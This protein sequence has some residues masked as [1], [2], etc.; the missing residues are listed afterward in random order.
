MQCALL[1]GFSC[2]GCASAP[3]TELWWCVYC[4]CGISSLPMPVWILLDSFHP[5]TQTMHIRLMGGWIVPRCARE[6]ECWRRR[7]SLR[8]RCQKLAFSGGSHLCCLTLIRQLRHRTASAG[9]FH[10]QTAWFKTERADERE[11]LDHLHVNQSHSFS[12][13]SK[14]H[15]NAC[16]ADFVTKLYVWDS[17]FTLSSMTLAHLNWF[18]WWGEKNRILPDLLISTLYFAVLFPARYIHKGQWQDAHL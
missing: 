11:T 2:L 14:W 12:A 13:T 6:R 3:R 10:P 16:S 17:E 8:D 7:G 5:L 15:A 18:V 9:Y 1:P 4:L